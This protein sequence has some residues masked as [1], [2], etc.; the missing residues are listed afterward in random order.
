MLSTASQAVH[1]RQERGNN[2]AK[3]WQ[4]ALQ[5]ALGGETTWTRIGLRQLSGMLIMVFARSHMQA[6]ARR[7]LESE[8][9]LHEQE[10]FHDACCVL[11]FA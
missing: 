7:G 8:I 1:V 3:A 5:A 4:A 2:N 9:S 6:R 10:W 11:K